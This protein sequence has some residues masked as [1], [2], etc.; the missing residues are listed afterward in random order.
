MLTPLP[1]VDRCMASERPFDFSRFPSLQEVYFGFTVNCMGG[2]LL[3]IPTALSTL[4]LATSPR[5]SSLRL[6]C[7]GSPTDQSVRTLIED[8][9]NDLRRIANEFTR[10]NHEFEGAVNLTVVRDRGFEVVLDTL[11]V[12]SPT[13]SCGG[14]HRFTVIRLLLP[15]DPS[16]ARAPLKKLKS[17]NIE[18]TGKSETAMASQEPFTPRTR[19]SGWSTPLNRTT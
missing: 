18:V 1:D 4:G 7:V 3:W 10:I 12:S 17:E 14:S 19:L 16:A 5:L 2:G 9:G 6:D 13:L 8:M 15:A 11:D